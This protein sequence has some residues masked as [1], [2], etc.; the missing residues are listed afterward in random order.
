MILL[1]EQSGQAASRPH[2]VSREI[3][4][5]MFVDVDH[6]GNPLAIEILDA[7]AR[8]PRKQLNSLPSPARTLSLAEAARESRLSPDTL[9]SQINK[10][11]LKATKRGRDWVVSATDLLNYLESRDA[12]GRPSRLDSSVRRARSA[13]RS[14][15]GV[16]HLAQ[17]GGSERT[18]APIPRRPRSMP[19]SS[20]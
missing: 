15:P 4:P 12:R 5:G 2:I 7:S 1:V 13:K 14:E 16:R 11:R 10:G 8:I 3:V 9:R 19:E 6:H 20:E 18:L 17:L